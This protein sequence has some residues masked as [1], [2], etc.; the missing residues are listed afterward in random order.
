MA[1]GRSVLRS[2]VTPA[3]LEVYAA[4][5]GDGTCDA[6][7]VRRPPVER[8]LRPGLKRK[9][10]NFRGCVPADHADEIGV[11]STRSLDPHTGF[12]F[13][14]FHRDIAFDLAHRGF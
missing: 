7:R 4:A 3:F 12:D 2:Q 6:D 8:R 10:G 11:M 1:N 5:G 13:V 14:R 9:V